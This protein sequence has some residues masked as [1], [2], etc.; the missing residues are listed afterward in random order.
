MRKN[1]KELL[2]EKILIIDGAMG[3]QIQD[4]KVPEDAWQGNEGCNELLNKTAPDI[5]SL[6]YRRYAE[7][8]ANLIKTN[9]FGAMAWVLE[10][11]N[12]LEMSY[13]LSYL[14]AKL[15]KNVCNEFNSDETPRFVLGSIGPGTKLPSLKHITYDEMYQGFKT[16]A[17]GLIDGGV[18][19]FLLETCQDPLQ[20][21]AGINALTDAKNELNKDIPIM[22]SVT[23]ELSGTMLIGTDITTIATI[24]EP[25]DIL[26]LGMNC[27]T[28]PIQAEK[29]LKL[30]SQVWHKP[31]SIHSNAGLPQNRGGQ[32]F[33]PMQPDEFASIQKKFINFD[34]VTF[35]GGCCGTTPK[36]IE[37]LANSIKE[38][39]PKIPLGTHKNSLASLF[40]SVTIKQKPAPLLIGER[41]NATGSKAF[42]ELL[43]AEDYEGTLSVAQEQ[44][45]A[46][47]HI[48]DVS[49]GFAGRDESKDMD[50]VISLYSQKISI[51]LMP[52]STQPK[53]LEKALKNIGGKA[54]INS[55][56]LEDG[57]EKF[58]E[59]CELS[60]RYGT[61]LICLTIDEKGMAKTKDRK[62]EIAKRI[63]KL[64][65]EKHNIRP[66]NLVFD[67]LTFTVGSGDD[68]YRTAAI[69]TI[70]A[71]REINK[72]FPEVGTT[73][74]LSNISFG[75]EKNARFYL[76]SVFLYHC[77]KA[78]LSTVII[79]V[80]HIIPIN[81]ISDFDKKICENLLFN[82]WENDDP[83]FKF[84]N[85]F[86]DVKVDNSSQTDEEFNKL[87]DKEKVEKLLIDG[88]KER[89]LKLV[90]DLKDR[91]SVELIVNE[92]LLDSMKVIGELFGNGEMQLPFVLQSAETM[93]KTVDFLNPY[94]PK[95]DKTTDTT[96]VLG[97]VKG[98]VHDVGK[99][100]V[101][102]ILSN[103]G[104]KVE[105]IGIKV[106]ISKYIEIIKTKDIQAIGMSGLLVK[107]TQVMLENLK[108]L[109]K[110]GISLPVLL[111]GAALT[112]SFVD[113][114]CRPVYDGAIFYC[115]DAF[116]GVIAMGRIENGDLNTQLAGDIVKNSSDN[117]DNLSKSKDKNIL[118]EIKIP[119]FKDIE[120]P[121][122]D[123][124]VPTPPFW[125]RK[126]LKID[127]NLP[128][129]WINK[130]ILFKQRW[131]YKKGKLSKDKYQQMIDND[132]FPLYEKLKNRLINENIY[133]PVLIYGYFPVKSDDKTL[134]IYHP[135]RLD[136]EPI[137]KFEFPR[138]NKKPYRAVSDF[139]KSDEFDVIALSMVS[140]GVE[141]DKY[142][143]E[144][145]KN[146]NFK[147]YHLMHGLAIELAESCAE[148]VHKQFR[149]DLDILKNE[150]PTI[151]DVK[152]R[153]Y[154]G[155]RYSFGYSA[156]P[157]MSGNKIIFDLLKPEEFGIDLTE[158]FLIVPEASTTAIISHHKEAKYF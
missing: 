120:M 101:D 41:S 69:E 83:L 68:E 134:Y 50:E 71:I 113:D 64:A 156:A 132:I 140:S 89:M 139:F 8:G 43:L 45:R 37:A 12:L 72:I 110:E 82:D 114:F 2:K 116:D 111:G 74:G 112:K 90:D 128:F 103:N 98:D 42:R 11:Y 108:E 109:K 31:I 153:G 104:F 73:L 46:G 85:H 119:D 142:E 10:D 23:I 126:I 147:E 117:S 100:L 77:L 6:I 30:L 141:F 3:T 66:E 61:A 56:N 48:L 51:P 130:R 24:L 22:V 81:K 44:V 75:L 40:N 93:K 154:Q 21:K 97:T 17:K 133:N 19:I 15:A 35:L 127:K 152:I 124:K 52:D 84:I 13:E 26:S 122:K 131:G 49:V 53:F 29:H 47:A 151:N 144:L 5:I 16:T 146:G 118:K 25:F 65:T 138:Q 18:D 59:I 92:W 105:N 62:V 102:I 32:T 9:T 86:S 107:S 27:G 78:G 95:Q 123:Y 91:V 28:G 60:K 135:D 58:D 158:S 39:K 136:E 57:I 54:I 36:H 94:L 129:E 4:I 70:E 145:Y 143:R 155:C 125:G 1:I 38:L 150:K 106:D 99:N 7:A 79:N 149:L 87:S 33:Y 76:N 80:K 67:V 137:Y 63:Y 121:S 157:D 34:G 88:D 14:G 148:I 115:R 96:L 20:I 55:V